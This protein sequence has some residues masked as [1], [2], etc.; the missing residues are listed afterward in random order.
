MAT[1]LLRRR[2]IATLAGAAGVAGVPLRARAAAPVDARIDSRLLTCW[3]DTP[4]RPSAFHAGLLG[5]PARALALPARGHDIA[6]HPARDG[7]ALVVARR[8]GTFLVRWHVATGREIARFEADDEF[9]FEGHL[10]F[11]PD[12]RVLY[13][14]ETDLIT[15]DGRIGVFD[16]LSLERLATWPCGGIGPHAIEWLPDGRL[17]VAV[18]GI[19][20]LPE[21]GRVKRN[22]GDMDPSLSFLDG[23]SGRLLSQHRPADPF[24]SVRH[25][26]QTADGRIAV[27]MQNEGQVARPLFAHLRGKQLVYGEADPGLL[28]R[29]GRYAGDIVSVGEYFAVSCTM[30]GVTALWVANGRAGA[31]FET[32]RVCATTSHGARLV[33]T[34]DGGDVWEIDPEVGAKGGSAIRHLRLPLALDNHASLLI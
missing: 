15:G 7:S 31:L 6:W 27:S 16:A 2:L 24:M 18:G 32:N 9:R 12:G 14:T 1:N 26:A 21:T 3:S 23:T 29:C 5:V 25:I 11:R 22:L 13:T 28:E 19:L 34:G 4:D 17:A 33:V 20:T 8:P 10:A 30:A